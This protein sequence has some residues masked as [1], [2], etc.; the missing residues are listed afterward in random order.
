M[1]IAVIVQRI[2]VRC[3]EPPRRID[4]RNS[5]LAEQLSAQCKLHAFVGI[6]MQLKDE[7]AVAGRRRRSREMHLGRFF[8]HHFVKLSVEQMLAHYV[9]I[10]TAPLHGEIRALEGVAAR[11]TSLASPGWDG[12]SSG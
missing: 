1:N 5:Y 7:R 3:I 4:D 12:G 9:H 11:D 8:E 2:A 10:S 6:Y